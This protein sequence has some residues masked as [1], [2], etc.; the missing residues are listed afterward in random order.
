MQRSAWEMFG[1]KLAELDL[2]NRSS[3]LQTWVRM[4]A[5]QLVE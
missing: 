2:S 4:I 3:D 5:E 1:V